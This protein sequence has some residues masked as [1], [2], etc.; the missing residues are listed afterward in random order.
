MKV[1]LSQFA[2]MQGVSVR[3]LWRRINEGKLQI[4][5]SETGRI[6]VEFVQLYL[7]LVNAKYSNLHFSFSTPNAPNDSR[8]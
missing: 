7:L 1:K 6:F 2:K 5:R 8:G 3:T 4:I